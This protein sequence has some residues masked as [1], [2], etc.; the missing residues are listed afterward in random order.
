MQQATLMTRRA[1][2]HT[3][4]SREEL[5][6]RVDATIRADIDGGLAG[7]ARALLEAREQTMT[8][9]EWSP[10]AVIEL[11][12]ADVQRRKSGWT[13]ADLTAAINDA[14]PDYLGVT[15][16]A[17]VGELLDTLTAE[18]LRIA[19]SLDKARP[20]DALL[21]VE[22]RL[23]NGDSSYVAPGSRLYATPEHVRTERALVAA[24]AVGG[25]AALPHAMARR[26]L[27]GLRESGIELGADQAAA[28][29]GVLTSGARVETLVGP[30]GTGKSFVV[31]AIARGWTDPAL[32]GGPPRRVFGL[33]TSQIATDVLIGEGL[34]A[35]NVDRW[36][37]TQQ[38]LTAGP[39]SDD[40]QPID[41]DEAWRLHAGDLVVVDESAMTDTVALA[42]IW[43]YVE[44]AGAK[45][46]LVGDHRQL[47]AVGAGGG[48]GPARWRREPLRARRGPPLHPRM[49]TRGLAPAPCR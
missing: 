11:A 24:T 22:L 37:T 23:A 29:H 13:R 47:A 40:P 31:G 48:D 26:F 3:G 2:S 45:L 6:D 5:L 38:R 28:V 44:A 39:G 12:L 7:V 41:G 35:R 46:L 27:D 16:G 14:L 17:D 15:D 32:H 8:P 1:K 18:A 42:A 19:D 33:A 49:G 20:G 34:T 25:A 30:A 21:P 4:E 43:A 10:Q 36:L 9:Q